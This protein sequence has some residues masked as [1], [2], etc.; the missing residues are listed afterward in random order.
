[1]D[2][3]NTVP[4]YLASNAADTWPNPRTTR[5]ASAKKPRDL[6]PV[7]RSCWQPDTNPLE[8]SGIQPID[9]N[10]LQPLFRAACNRNT[11]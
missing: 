11:G 5:L 2:G 6:R 8:G 9:P 3:T 4:T 10:R 7:W 1:M